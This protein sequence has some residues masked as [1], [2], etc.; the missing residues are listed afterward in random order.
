MNGEG[1]EEVSEE[2]NG[3]GKGREGKVSDEENE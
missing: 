1:E 2:E 3:L